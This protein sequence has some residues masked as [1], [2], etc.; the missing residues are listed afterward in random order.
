MVTIEPCA[1]RGCLTILEQN[2]HEKYLLHVKPSG[3]GRIGCMPFSFM[4][5]LMGWHRTG[6]LSVVR[7]LDIILSH[8]N[9][10]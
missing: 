1:Y 7:L 9:S 3:C 4:N 5:D 6:G 10:K 8:V 2:L